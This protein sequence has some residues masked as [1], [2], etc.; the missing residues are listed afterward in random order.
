MAGKMEKMEFFGEDMLPAG[1]AADGD[2]EGMK[3]ADFG[4]SPE[5]D[6]NRAFE[7]DDGEIPRDEKRS[8]GRPAVYTD[9][10]SKTVP[11]KGVPKRML[12]IAK[13]AFPGDASQRD[14]FV[15]YL[16]VNCPEFAADRDLRRL[17]LNEKQRE[18]VDSCET[19]EYMAL[20]KRT[21]AMSDKIDRLNKQVS[22]LT[23]ML[24]LL[25]YQYFG[26]NHD[27]KRLTADRIEVEDFMGY[28]KGDFLRYRDSLL[29]AFVRFAVSTRA[30]DGVFFNSPKKKQR[31]ISG[32]DP[33]N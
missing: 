32:E 22:V 3:P 18:L 12:T 6:P 8:R 23:G 7:G 33:E 29:A 15:A 14:C 11:V 24:S 4:L 2:E 16:I 13:N 28:D 1:T 9:D 19:S 5:E 31:N 27:S 26:N 20:S 30:R 25:M 17:G 21:Q 10:P